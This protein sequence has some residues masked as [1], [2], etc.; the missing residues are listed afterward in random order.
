M[1]SEVYRHHRPDPRSRPRLSTQQHRAY[2]R[3][4]RQYHRDLH[5]QN[6]TVTVQWL[7]E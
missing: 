4:P 6:M 2:T 3:Y 1:L 7:L 5:E